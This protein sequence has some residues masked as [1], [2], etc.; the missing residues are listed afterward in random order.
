MLYKPEYKPY[1]YLS[2]AAIG[3]TAGSI[4]PGVGTVAGGV[5]GGVADLLGG[6]FGAGKS[7]WSESSQDQKNKMASTL[8]Y[9]GIWMAKLGTGSA[10]PLF[11]YVYNN[12]KEQ[13]AFEGRDISQNDFIDANPWLRDKAYYYMGFDKTGAKIINQDWV[14]RIWRWV[15][16]ANYN[17]Y[18]PDADVMMEATVK[19]AIEA[20][21]NQPAATTTTGAKALKDYTAA[22][23]AALTP[24]KLAELTK[25]S[26]T[27][28][29]LIYGGAGIGFILLVVVI[30]Y[31][32]RKGKR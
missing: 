32:A 17:P 15:N 12:L 11:A 19:T 2:G 24:A 6:I 20:N 9:N 27:K 29:Y 14:D 13:K 22:E 3:A 10:D 7:V 21:N 4:V 8:L 26:N 25:A 16:Y 23:L 5:V 1:S 31:F 28:K 30:I 18:N